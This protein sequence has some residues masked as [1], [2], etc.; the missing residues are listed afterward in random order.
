MFKKSIL[1]FVF[2]ASLNLFAGGKNN[3]T[4][5]IVPQETTPIRIAQ[6]ISQHEPV[7]L[8]TYQTTGKTTQILAWTGSHWVDISLESYTN[9]S[10]FTTR[11]SH[12]ILVEKKNVPAPDVLIPDGTWCSTGNRLIST[13]PRIMIHLLG[14]YF[15]FPYRTW[16]TFANHSRCSIETINPERINIPWWHYRGDRLFKKRR[17]SKVNT[18]LKNWYYLDIT[19]PTPI[20]LPTSVEVI[21]EYVETTDKKV[22]MR[23]ETTLFEKSTI[24]AFTSGEIPAAEVII[25]VKKK[26]W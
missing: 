6:E 23:D 24:D 20:E 21:T 2:L 11:P 25:P 8:V 4:M 1:T 19:Q 22:R 9:G 10:F 14:R 13:D 12:V 17:Q 7:L 18:D 3:I 26:A 16:K 5:L 15:D